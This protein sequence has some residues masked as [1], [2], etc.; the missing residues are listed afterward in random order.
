M[1]S[2][3]KLSALPDFAKPYK[4]KGYDVKKSGD[5]YQLFKV[6]SKRV[7]GKKYPQP[8]Y[9]YVGTIYPDRGLVPKKQ[10]I[11]TADETMLEYGLSNFIAKRFK[12]DLTRSMHNCVA[13]EANLAILNYIFG[14]FDKRVAMLSY[15]GFAMENIPELSDGG[16]KRVEKLSAKLD[17]LMQQLITDKYDRN[18]L[19]S[20]LRDIKV[21]PTKAIPAIKY[22]D[23]V[24]EIFE[25]YGVNI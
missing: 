17:T 1:S 4:T 13:T 22:P 11:G 20:R 6:T 15:L 25:K 2:N 21:C 5:R 14:V 10:S 3:M 24:M 16:I 9:T 12:R 7:E 23:D 19:I 8:V 18:Y